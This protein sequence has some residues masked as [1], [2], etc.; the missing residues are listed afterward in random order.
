MK[1]GYRDQ[2]VTILS[3]GGA[4]DLLDPAAPPPGPLQ[5]V[6]LGI[7]ATQASV[8]LLEVTMSLV[9]VADIPHHAGR[10]AHQGEA[11][12]PSVFDL[13]RTRDGNKASRGFHIARRR[14]L[15]LR[16]L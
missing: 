8:N 14:P 9:Q 5:S 1:Q 13:I 12:E 3:A 16:A 2:S 11:R 15:L 7:Q 4:P 10:R 6:C